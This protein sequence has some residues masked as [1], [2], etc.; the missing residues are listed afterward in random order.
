MADENNNQLTGTQGHESELIDVQG[1]KASLKKGGNIGIYNE[2]ICST[3][4]GTAAKVTNTVPK[5][6]TLTSGA[7]IIVKFTYAITVANATLQVGTNAAK[8]IYFQGAALEANVIKAGTSVLLSYNGTSFNIIGG[9]GTKYNAGT[10]IDI[11]NETISVDSNVALLEEEEQSEAFMP[12]YTPGVY[13]GTCATAAGT[14]A[15]TLD[16]LDYQLTRARSI[17]V[18]FSNAITVANAT[19]NIS[20]KGAKPIYYRGE[21]LEADVI[22]A[23]D[24]VTFLYDGTNYVI[25]N[26]EH[27]Y[28]DPYYDSTTG[29]IVYPDNYPV[30]YDSTSG[31]LVF[32]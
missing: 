32:D 27:G 7:K 30:H 20:S 31:M 21:A 19:L 22:K 18:T 15:K 24:I 4:G 16:I 3:A 5:S 6:F 10:G 12:S 14:A 1:M 13:V 23:A 8:P 29:F 25:T 11:T 28:S 9:L 26:I 17:V 2:C